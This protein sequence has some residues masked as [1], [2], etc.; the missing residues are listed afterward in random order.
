MNL[1]EAIARAENGDV[2]AMV[3]MAEYIV[4]DENAKSDIDPELG[5]KVLE[6]LDKAI[7][8]G[9]DRA[10]NLLGTMYYSGRVLEKDQAKAMDW[11]QKAADRGNAISMLNLGYGYYYGNGL[12]KDMEMAYKM[13][14]KAAL[15]GVHEAIYKVGDMYANGY[16]VEKD[17][18]AAFEM[19]GRSYVIAKEHLDE[20]E[21]KQMYS[22]TCLRLGRCFRDGVGTERDMLAAEH[23]FA[24]AHYYFKVREACGDYFIEEGLKESKKALESILKKS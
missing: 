13:F 22:S 23:F 14:T 19:Y 9:D 24:E 18:K 3:D 20:L 15:L 1:Q 8:A 17:D 6:Y 4:W 10:M 5:K 2:D 11:Y 7:E 21:G 16:F 12:K